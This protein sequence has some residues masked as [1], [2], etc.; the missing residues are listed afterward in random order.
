MLRRMDGWVASGF[1]GMDW[2][3]AAALG[4]R[5]LMWTALAGTVFLLGRVRI[6]P[7][8]APFAIAFLAA[9]LMARHPAASAPDLPGCLRCT[10]MRTP[11]PNTAS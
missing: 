6:P 11:L 10:R 5:G 7:T 9:A 3:G 4:R 2:D 1:Q 8:L